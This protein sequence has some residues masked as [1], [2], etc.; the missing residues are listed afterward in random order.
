M[1][2][3]FIFC[4]K[5][6]RKHEYWILN[7]FYRVNMI[8]RLV[9]SV[10]VSS[11]LLFMSKLRWKETTKCLNRFTRQAI[12]WN[13]ANSFCSK[14][15]FDIM[16]TMYFYDGVIH[17]PR[18][19]IFGY[20]WPP[21]PQQSTSV[22]WY[23]KWKKN[24]LEQQIHKAIFNIFTYLRMLTFKE[25]SILEIISTLVLPLQHCKYL[26][27]C[28]LLVYSHP[29]FIY[30]KLSFFMLQIFNRKQFKSWLF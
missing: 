11:M 20:F 24:I 26:L 12:V 13:E 8:S 18:G 22:H 14:G 1:F 29:L 28:K 7:N 25:I 19:Q 6:A 23:C 21:P 5:K 4:Y 30:A 16:Y 10:A 3:L 15:T 9:W 27:F 17:K 2:F